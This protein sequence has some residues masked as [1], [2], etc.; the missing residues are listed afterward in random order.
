MDIE[1]DTLAVGRSLGG[2]GALQRAWEDGICEEGLVDGGLVNDVRRVAAGRGGLGS[3]MA[4]GGRRQQR[5]G[6]PSVHDG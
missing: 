6:R 1:L 4:D 5:E 2:N 3:D